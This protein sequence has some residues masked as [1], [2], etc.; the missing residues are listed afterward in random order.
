MGSEMCIR[1][2][3]LRRLHLIKTPRL[4]A[5]L[6]WLSRDPQPDPHDHP[7]GFISIVLRG[8]YTEWTPAGVRTIRWL[9]VKRRE[10]AHRITACAPGTL[11]L[12]FCWA[13]G[14]QSRRWGFHTPE[15]WVDW[16][17]YAP[18]GL[19]RDR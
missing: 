3:Y 16:Q 17:D 8:H 13:P 9:N 5:M 10:D 6:H 1:D 19:E 12:V 7:V 2:R 15:G 4:G 11:T 18:I 14:G